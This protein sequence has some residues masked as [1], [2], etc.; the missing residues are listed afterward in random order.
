MS[1]LND[2][3]DDQGG[4]AMPTDRSDK[5]P[6]LGLAS[7]DEL[8]DELLAR[9]GRTFHHEVSELPA[10]ERAVAITTLRL[11]VPRSEREYR[12]VDY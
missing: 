3:P 9:L 12:T 6:R 8:L 2:V 1:Y 4:P 11:S 5:E 10:V 7:T